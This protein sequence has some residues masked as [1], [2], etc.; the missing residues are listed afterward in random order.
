[1]TDER[2]TLTANQMLFVREAEEQELEVDYTYSGRGMYGAYCP[3]VRLEAE[4]LLRYKFTAAV[5]RDS[6]GLGMVVY[7]R[8]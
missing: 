6:L 3:A 7:A 8:I 5:A 1:M 4:D 2:Y